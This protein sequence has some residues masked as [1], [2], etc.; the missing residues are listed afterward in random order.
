MSKVIQLREKVVR[1]CATFSFSISLFPFPRPTE[2]RKHIDSHKSAAQNMTERPTSLSIKFYKHCVERNSILNSVPNHSTQQIVRKCTNPHLRHN[3]SVEIAGANHRI[4]NK[5]LLMNSSV[6][7]D[8]SYLIIICTL[9]RKKPRPF[10]C[11]WTSEVSFS[12]V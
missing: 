8:T 5:W 2:N 6:Q 12:D 3:K 10:P 11:H 7:Q 1:K 4:T 9:F